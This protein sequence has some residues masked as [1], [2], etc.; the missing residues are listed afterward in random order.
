M[1]TDAEAQVLAEG[2]FLAVVAFIKRDPNVYSLHTPNKGVYETH[3]ELPGRLFIFTDT[4]S[5]GISPQIRV[6][7][8]RQSIKQEEVWVTQKAVVGESS[9]AMLLHFLAIKDGKEIELYIN[10][11]A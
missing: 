9:P 8:R 10:Q 6:Y 7:L 4:S 1:V 5:Q 2:V 11:E 3:P